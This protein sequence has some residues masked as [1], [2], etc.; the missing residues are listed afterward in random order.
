MEAANEK[1]LLVGS[2]TKL[3]NKT[4][5]EIAEL[6]YEKSEDS[7]ELS[8][9][10]GALDLILQHDEKRVA[11]IKESAGVNKKALEEKFE[12]GYKKGYK[13]G[14][15]EIEAELKKT[16]GIESDSIGTDLVKEVVNTISECNR[17]SDD[18]IKTHPIFLELEKN[19]VPKSEY[20]KV[21]TDFETFKFN[22]DRLAKLER[23]KADVLN[24]FNGMNPV[25]SENS[26]VAQT[27]L[28]DFLS[29]FEGYDYE[30]SEDGNHLI[31]KGDSRLEDNHGNP[32]K[33]TDFVQNVASN[34]YEFR[35]AD[36]VQNTGN[37]N[38]GKGTKVDLPK[39]E[40]EY[41]SKYAELKIQGRTEEAI[42][43]NIAWQAAQKT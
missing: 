38:N 7:D 10:P 36:D 33:F 39:T 8:I 30:L 17:P 27:R 26:K 5:D 29:K 12:Q 1:D 22:Q 40:K 37:R 31:K 9:K 15:T 18:Q 41:L 25:I 34:C 35:Q 13:E 32:I 14:K 16:A 11:N 2:L 6:I 4:E 42:A 21:Q 19:S 24:V 23:V 28:N 3:Y 43:L 20:E